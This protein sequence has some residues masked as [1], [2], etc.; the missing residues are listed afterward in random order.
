MLLQLP[1][2]GPL[3][4]RLL[5]FLK[6][7]NVRL[8][9][10]NVGNYFNILGQ[11]FEQPSLKEEVHYLKLGMMARERDVVQRGNHSCEDLVEK[12]LDFK[13]DKD[14]NIRCSQWFRHS[15]SSRQVQYAALDVIKPFKAYEKLLLLPDLSQ[16]IDP[17]RA[18]PGLVLDIVPSHSRSNCHKAP[19]GYRVGT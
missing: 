3:P 19:Q 12:V 8:I 17:S 10:V 1:K 15:L 9:G 2:T 18:K 5:S 6:S 7:P 13:L 16:H 11:D 14:R 4:H